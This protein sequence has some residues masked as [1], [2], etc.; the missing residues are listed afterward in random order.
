MEGKVGEKRERERKRTSQNSNSIISIYRDLQSGSL[1]KN[2]YSPLIQSTYFDVYFPMLRLLSWDFL[3]GTGEKHENL[4][5]E[6]PVS[7]LRFEIGSSQILNCE[8]FVRYFGLNNGHKG[9][10]RPITI[11]KLCTSKLF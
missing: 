11:N 5:S 10:K 2:G 6:L 7:G 1:K 9:N 3:G 4:K 8:Y